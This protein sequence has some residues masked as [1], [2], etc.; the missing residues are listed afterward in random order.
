[1]TVNL[2]VDNQ[3]GHNV[4]MILS[5]SSESYSLKIQACFVQFGDGRDKMRILNTKVL[6][7]LAKLS[8]KTWKFAIVVRFHSVLPGVIW[9]GALV[10]LK[11]NVSPWKLDRMCILM[12]RNQ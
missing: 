12:I 7:I 6:N 5:H 9:N 8:M 1:M 11:I 3:Y 2:L 4:F 10:A